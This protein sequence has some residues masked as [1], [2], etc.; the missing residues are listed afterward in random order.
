LVSKKS[1]SILALGLVLVV[2]VITTILIEAF[3]PKYETQFI[4]FGLLGKAKAAEE[5]YPNN[6]STIDL[7][8]RVDWYIYVYNHIRGDQ[9]VMIRV[10]LLNSTMETPNDQENKPSPTAILNEIP[11]SLKNNETVIVPFSWSILERVSQQ[12]STTIESL[13]MN[14]KTVL[15]ETADSKSFFIMVFE[16]WVYDKSLQEYR[17]GWSSGGELISTS[18]YMGFRAS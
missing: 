2:I 8:S 4:E 1:K 5:Y 11:L 18:V 10:K 13:M 15:V 3:W 14:D 16:L 9:K 7:G 17:F 6:N 12:D